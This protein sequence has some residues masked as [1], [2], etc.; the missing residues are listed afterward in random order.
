[1]PSCVDEGKF[2]SHCSKESYLGIYYS[3]IIEELK[4]DSQNIGVGFLNL[5]QKDNSLRIFLQFLCQDTALVIALRWKIQRWSGKASKYSDDDWNDLPHILWV[6]LSTITIRVS[7]SVIQMGENIPIRFD[8][9]WSCWYSVMSIRM[10][11]P[12]FSIS[13]SDWSLL[14]SFLSLWR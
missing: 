2:P 10:N 9:V 6:S 12:D 3:S 7:T 5:V 13:V 8:T 4:E 14:S 1:M 11:A